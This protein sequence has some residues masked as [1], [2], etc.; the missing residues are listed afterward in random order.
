M[1]ASGPAAIFS[2]HLR[3]VRDLIRRDPVG[4][5]SYFRRAV[6]LNELFFVYRPEDRALL[7]AASDRG[8]NASVTDR[9]RH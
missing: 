2:D 9:V 7:R 6:R 3:Q 5:Y 8:V 4:D 1:T